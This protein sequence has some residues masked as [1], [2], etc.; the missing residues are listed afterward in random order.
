M[1]ELLPEGGPADSGRSSHRRRW[2]IVAVAAVLL[3][4]IGWYLYLVLDPGM[5]GCACVQPTPSV[6]TTSTA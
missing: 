4:A 6:T 1:S 5:K 2:L 3:L